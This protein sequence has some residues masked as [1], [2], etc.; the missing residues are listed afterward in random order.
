MLPNLRGGSPLEIVVRMRVPSHKVG[1]DA[2]LANFELS[3]VAQDNSTPVTI[4][5]PFVTTFDTEE[6][7]ALLDSNPD[8]IE[9]VQLLMNARARLEAIAKMDAG[10]YD[11]S[12]EVFKMV[13]EDNDLAFCMTQS[14]R[15]ARERE[16]LA[17]LEEAL[18]SREND[19]V[20]R[21]RMAYGREAIRKGK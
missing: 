10:D 12:M 17:E 2:H 4:T 16:E 6:A 14:P 3:Y 13:A 1:A 20:I 9:V 21:K 18:E 15:L 8:V 5:T 19:V 11:H 7:V